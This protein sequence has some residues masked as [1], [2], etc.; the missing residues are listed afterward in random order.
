MFFDEL[1]YDGLP[2]R[3]A[4]EYGQYV[5][6]TKQGTHILAGK[7]IVKAY[8]AAT[9]LD[10]SACRVSDSVGILPPGLE[11]LLYLKY[12]TPLKTGEELPLVLLIPFNFS[13]KDNNMLL[14][15]ISDLKQFVVKSF[16]DHNKMMNKS[17][18]NKIVN[19][20]FF[21]RYCKAHLSSS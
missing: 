16:S 1:S 3:G 5:L 21:L 10:L 20:E 2:M 11:N 6:E 4:I 19:T 17:V 9:E 7:P 14:R 8:Q 13:L 18:Q 12:P 15:G